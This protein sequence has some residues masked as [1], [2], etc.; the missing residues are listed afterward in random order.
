VSALLQRVADALRAGRSR[1]VIEA[2]DQVI[3]DPRASVDL[4]AAI[5]VV[6]QRAGA[7][8]QAARAYRWVLERRPGDLEISNNLAN[9]LSSLGQYAEAAELLRALLEVHGAHA[10]TLSNLGVILRKCGDLDGAEQH[11]RQALAADPEH[12]LAASNLSGLLETGQQLEEAERIASTA[13]AAHPG[14]P[15]LSMTRARCQRAR[16]DIA[17]AIAT[18][19]AVAGADLAQRAPG[20]LYQL[21]QL[22]DRAGD[23]AA[24]WGTLTAVNMAVR[25]A[26]RVAG[27]ATEPP[28][29]AIATASRRVPVWTDDDPPSESPA[30]IVG[31]PRSGTT[32][33][34]QILRAHGA[35]EVMTELPM[36]EDC[37]RELGVATPYPEGLAELEPAE[38]DRLRRH[39]FERAE[40]YLGHAP[41]GL[42]VD[43]LPLNTLKVGLIHRLF[44]AAPIVLVVRHP[45]DV[46]LSCLFQEFGAGRALGGA[47][48]GGLS[49]AAYLL[50]LQEAA[51]YY[52]AV[53]DSFQTQVDR[54]RL[55]VHRLRYEDLVDDLEATAGGLCQALGLEYRATMRD[56]HT[57]PTRA[58]SIRTPSYHQ[59]TQPIYTH[60]RYRWTAYRDQLASVFP[61]LEPWVAAHG[62]PALDAPLGAPLDAELAR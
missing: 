43:E 26:W 9:T 59:V 23:H 31:F 25:D 27:G 10:P 11:Y 46:V 34:G 50:D 3:A 19:S 12:L 56:F 13:L 37:Q 47:G 38:L 14:H 55:Q 2:T 4:I 48:A 49:A 8:P 52:D 30:F 62:Y 53:M 5:G 7:A 20:V 29:E 33:V 15:S 35:T 57:V 24:A 17:G 21:A 28:V 22:Q 6:C 54:L 41:Q 18:L 58:G 1:E 36:I 44:A 51:A 45:C 16:G 32:L 40:H 42:L 60:A 39:Y 61:I